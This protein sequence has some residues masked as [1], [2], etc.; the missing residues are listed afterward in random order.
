MNPSTHSPPSV[1]RRV[2]HPFAKPHSFASALA[3]QTSESRSKSAHRNLSRTFPASPATMKTLVHHS[4][5]SSSRP[6]RPRLAPRSSRASA[7]RTPGTPPPAP[8]LRYTSAART[9]TPNFETLPAHHPRTAPPRLQIS[10]R[11]VPLARARPRSPVP[12]VGVQ[13][14]VRLGCNSASSSRACTPCDRARHRPVR[15]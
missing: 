8:S 11:R 3:S 4:R 12:P 7:Q 5:P 9:P 15:R 14:R 10:S 1:W 13:T 2:S 6:A